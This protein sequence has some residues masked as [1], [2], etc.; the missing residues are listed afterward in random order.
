MGGDRNIERG[1]LLAQTAEIVAAYVANN[2][3]GPHDV[4]GFIHSV[5]DKLASLAA[6]LVL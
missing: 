1:E 3:L 2:A 4:P 5:F 6:E